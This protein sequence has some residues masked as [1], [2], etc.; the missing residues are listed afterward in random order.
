M[1]LNIANILLAGAL[2]CSSAAFTACTEDKVYEVD[3][4]G[5][6]QA[7]DYED[8]IT[9]SVDQATNT[10]TLT[11]AAKG[12]YPVWIVDGKQ[13]STAHTLSRY[14]RK[15]G[16]YSIDVKIGNA[17]GV[18]QGTL[19]KTFH[20]DKTAMTGFGGMKYDSPFNMWPDAKKSEPSFYY[21]PGWA[22]IANPGYTPTADGFAVNLPSATTDQW[23]AQVHITTDIALQAGEHYDWSMIVTT[24]QALPGM[25]V[26]I[27]PEGDDAN[28]IV[29]KR[30]AIPA[31]EPLC[32]YGHDSEAAID[33]TNAVFT[34]DFGGCADNTDVTIENICLKK[35]SD[36]DGTEWPAVP[37][38]PEPNWV[39]ANSADNLWH[40]AVTGHSFYYAPGWAQIADPGYTETDGGYILELPAATS[41]RRQCQFA[42]Q[43][44][45]AFAADDAVDVLVVVNSS[46]S[47]K[48][49]FKLVEANVDDTDEGK[50]DNNFFF[51]D[52]K[53]L[54]E[55]Q[56]VRVFWSNVKPCADA[57]HATNFVFDFGG[58]PEG[59]TVEIKQIIVQ[60]HHD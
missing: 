48:A 6:P 24:T 55:G 25:T 45:L 44:G 16:D 22:Q 32:I 51:A 28:F 1:K 33:F 58:N 41:D 14:Y 47:F 59:T 26:K 30:F 38:T 39:D 2:V 27:H 18:S 19:T 8:A 57:M 21:A 4:Y 20:I 7:S 3:A 52:E 15:A 53:D 35:T 40:G 10:A 50:R 42:L 11:F 36:D 46:A 37:D 56:D 29:E 43:T 23:Q 49:M 17:N 54:V 9:V 34:F 13:Y 5:V 31:G 12:V 60:K